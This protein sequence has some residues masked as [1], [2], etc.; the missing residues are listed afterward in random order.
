MLT[1]VQAI[2]SALLTAILV[3]F[4][5]RRY[6][7]NLFEL[8]RVDEPAVPAILVNNNDLDVVAGSEGRRVEEPEEVRKL[9]DAI[10]VSHGVKEE[11]KVD[12]FRF[13][14]EEYDIQAEVNEEPPVIAKGE[15]V[16]E[17][18]VNEE[19][20][21]ETSLPSESTQQV[22]QLT[23]SNFESISKGNWLILAH[24]PWHQ[25]SAL[26]LSHFL[27]DYPTAIRNPALNF[28]TV[29]CDAYPKLAAA[30]NVKRYPSLQLM[31]EE[32]RLREWPFEMRKL[33][34]QASWF[35]LHS[36]WTHLPVYQLLKPVDDS[37]AL[38][39]FQIDIFNKA[40]SYI[41]S[42]YYFISI[43]IYLFS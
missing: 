28:A 5:T 36:Q 6:G 10:F 22:L 14:E 21:I 1:P 25:S 18:S 27:S 34:Q 17:E 4:F 35:L 11:V 12:K 23:E 42:Q 38:S 43:L 9:L 33:D 41:V 30:L 16:N 39:A 31:T 3:E 7:A 32:G 13:R 29:D 2:L 40:G 20:V 26:Y 19:P 24:V 15:S 37:L 8:A